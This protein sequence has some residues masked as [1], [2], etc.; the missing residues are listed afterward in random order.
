MRESNVMVRFVAGFTYTHEGFS[1]QIA[2]WIT[3]CCHPLSIIED[4]ELIDTFCMLH[5]LVI[6]PTWFSVGQDIHSMYAMMKRHVISMF[7][8]IISIRAAQ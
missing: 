8:V 3:K 6:V 1:F 4:E 2:K 7:E 5:A